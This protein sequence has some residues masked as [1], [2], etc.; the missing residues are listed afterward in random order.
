MNFIRQRFG[1][2]LLVPISV[3]LVTALIP[4]PV[5]SGEQIYKVGIAEMGVTDFFEVGWKAFKYTERGYNSY[6]G[7]N[8]YISPCVKA[9]D[10]DCIEALSYRVSNSQEWK[11]AEL[12]S[13]WT[14]PASGVPLIGS[15]KG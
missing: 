7:A 9:E 4:I 11:K 10:S 12:D 8:I 13:S 3:L 2:S 1:N 5:A 15:Y 14:I 6:Y